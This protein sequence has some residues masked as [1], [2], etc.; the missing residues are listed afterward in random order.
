MSEKKIHELLCKVEI[1]RREAVR[2]LIIGAEFSLPV[3]MSFAMGG[4]SMSILE[5]AANGTA[6]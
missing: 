1:S 3:V 6:S 4:I 2:K 5:P